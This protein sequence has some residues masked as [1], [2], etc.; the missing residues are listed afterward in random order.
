[1]F[2]GG[3]ACGIKNYVFFANFSANLSPNFALFDWKYCCLWAGVSWVPNLRYKRYER[4]KNT[5]IP[6]L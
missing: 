4:I 3:W 2:F 5:E 1:M 6:I